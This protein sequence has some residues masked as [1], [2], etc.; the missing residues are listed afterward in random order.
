MTKFI[1]VRFDQQISFR[2]RSEARRFVLNEGDRN[3]LWNIVEVP[4][5]F[6]G[7]CED[8]YAIVEAA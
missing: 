3:R 5:C 1:A 6:A 8:L 7:S 2:T 4:V